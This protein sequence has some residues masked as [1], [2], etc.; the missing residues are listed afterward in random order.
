M[1]YDSNLIEWMKERTITDK[2]KNEKKNK[3][4]HLD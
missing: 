3:K 4:K 1:I 2:K